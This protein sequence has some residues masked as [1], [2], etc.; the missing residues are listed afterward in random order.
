MSPALF[1]GRDSQ[2]DPTRTDLVD[3]GLD[4]F[5]SQPGTVVRRAAVDVVAAV[6]HVGEELVQQI[7]VGRM[8][9]DAVHSG[10]DG[11]AG[12][13]AEI[14]D[15]AGEF[16]HAQGARHGK[17]LATRRRVGGH[18]GGDRRGCDGFAAAD[19]GMTHSTDV[20]QLHE[21]AAAV[22]VHGVRDL[23]PPG[24]VAIGEHPWRIQVRAVGR[25]RHRRRLAD[26]QARGRALRV[27]E[28]SQLRRRRIGLRA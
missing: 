10:V 2:P 22:D 3:D 26:D 21:H 1:P 12:R 25:S 7:A 17:R 9:L 14:R 28:R 16:V 5:G 18:V 8:D 19:L 15:D 13:G 6:G 27:V 23:G 4:H 24:L 20:P 11:T